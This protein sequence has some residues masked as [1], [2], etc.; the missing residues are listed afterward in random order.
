MNEIERD[1]ERRKVE[2]EIA[3]IENERRISKLAM[4]RHLAMLDAER[5]CR[6]ENLFAI[7]SMCVL[8]WAFVLLICIT[9]V[10]FL[11]LFK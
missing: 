7:L 9:I 2:H 6:N 1:I 4:A 5:K 8:I 10:M 3:R 11:P